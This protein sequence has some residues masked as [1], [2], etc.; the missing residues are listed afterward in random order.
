MLWPMVDVLI[1]PQ[2]L[3]SIAVVEKLDLEFL[4]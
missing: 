2:T 3:Q 4:E 1:S